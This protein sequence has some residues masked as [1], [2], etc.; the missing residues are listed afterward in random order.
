MFIPIISISALVQ[1]Y[2]MGYMASDPHLNRFYS[3]LSFFTFFMLILI[4]GEN[5]FAFAQI[6]ISD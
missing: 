5:L 3:Y 6:L 1:L 2:S 4:T